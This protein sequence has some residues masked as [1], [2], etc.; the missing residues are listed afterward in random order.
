[1]QLQTK[2][3]DFERT[4]AICIVAYGYPP[5]TYLTAPWQICGIFSATPWR[6][7]F[8]RNRSRHAFAAKK[9]G[10]AARK[11]ARISIAFSLPQDLRIALMFGAA[12]FGEPA[13]SGSRSVGFHIAPR[14]PHS[15]QHL[16][17]PHKCFNQQRI[18]DTN[19]RLAAPCDLNTCG[20]AVFRKQRRVG[21]RDLPSV[22]RNAPEV[23]RKTQQLKFDPP[24]HAAKVLQLKPIFPSNEIMSFVESSLRAKR[25]NPETTSKNWIASS[26]RSSQ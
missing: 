25:S 17:T 18:F 21:N 15:P 11:I 24:D 12:R 22:C 7:R 19:K 5:P 26:L 1:M 10:L 4:A 2:P 20:G 16:G 14:R 9:P 6:T 8:S 13:S 3:Y 23:R